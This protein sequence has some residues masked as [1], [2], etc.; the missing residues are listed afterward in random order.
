M[1][2]WLWYYLLVL[3]VVVAYWSVVNWEDITRDVPLLASVGVYPKEL[4]YDE[5]AKVPAEVGV[6][7]KVV[8]SQ[9]SYLRIRRLISVRY[10]ITEGWVSLI[11]IYVST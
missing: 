1:Y 6:V 7:A 5:I 2:N 3:S 4:L 11:Y 10:L 9:D 8:H